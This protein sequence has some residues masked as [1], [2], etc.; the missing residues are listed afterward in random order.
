MTSPADADALRAR[1]SHEIVRIRFLTG[2][3]PSEAEVAELRRRWQADGWL[4]K[5]PLTEVVHLLLGVEDRRLFAGRG[6]VAVVRK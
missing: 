4:R 6:A 1:P 2:R 5:F 3:W